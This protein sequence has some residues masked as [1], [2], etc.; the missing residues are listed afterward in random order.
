MKGMTRF[1]S[2]GVAAVLVG[3]VVAPGRAAAS[4]AAGFA[5]EVVEYQGQQ[6]AQQCRDMTYPVA[7]HPGEPRRFTVWGRLCGPAGDLD[8]RTV[9]LLV[10]GGTY[11]HTYNDFPF[12]PEH[13]SFVRA[14]TAA[15]YATLNIDRIGHGLS[16]HRPSSAEVTIDTSANTL[17]Y[18]IEDLRAGTAGY[19]FGKVI[20]VGHSY[21]EVISRT[22]AASHH[23]VDGLILSGAG[24]TGNVVKIPTVF[25][26]IL[27]P[28]QMDP[29]FQQTQVQ[30][31]DTT[32]LAGRRCQVMYYPGSYEP[33]VCAA[34][35]RTKDTISAGEI[36][37]FYEFSNAR[38][39]QQLTAPVLHVEGEHDTF[40][41]Y[42]TCSQPYEP[43]QQEYLFYP[44][45]ACFQ[46]WVEP[47][48]G[49]VNNL[50]LGAPLYY[51]RAMTWANERVGLTLDSPI[52]KCAG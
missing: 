11:D 52:A 20:L 51:A 36:A 49:H 46:S 43:P 35:E 29:K 48:S 30:P 8:R 44:R 50:S 6:V 26:S 5:T 22:Y 15:G 18:I 24:H 12:R 2:L 27:Y 10:H 34:D 9:M 31:G 17:Q 23:D 38:N 40:F 32:S 41:C 16:D 25:A 3:G 21:G 33:E 19:R 45:A 42:T 1:I 39:T 7:L 28:A 37:T 4:E 13:Y 47:D 14:A